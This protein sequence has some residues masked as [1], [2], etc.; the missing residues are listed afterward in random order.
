MFCS[1]KINSFSENEEI[2]YLFCFLF[3]IIYFHMIQFHFKQ[4]KR[5]FIKDKIR[6][7]QTISNNKI[8]IKIKD[9]NI[10]TSKSIEI[11][12]NYSN[13]SFTLNHSTSVDS[14]LSKIFSKIALKKFYFTITFSKTICFFYCEANYLFISSMNKD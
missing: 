6:F 5:C 3:L 13:Y 7:F 2:F 11:Y 8:D 1:S 4:N 9:E 10:K 14:D 12:S